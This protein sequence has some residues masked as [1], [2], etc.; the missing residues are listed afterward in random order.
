MIVAKC[1]MNGFF[2]LKIGNVATLKFSSLK[3]VLVYSISFGFQSVF[4]AEVWHKPVL[5][6]NT[7]INS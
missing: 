2:K 6:V 3:I 4:R 7:L 5:V 1:D